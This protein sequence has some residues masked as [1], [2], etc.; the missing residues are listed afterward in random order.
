MKVVCV[1]GMP[2]CGKEEFL[3]IARSKGF[4]VVRMGD[5]VREEA[6]KAGIPLKDP[7]VGSFANEERKK[8]GFDIWAKRT[9]PRISSEFSLVDGV[10]GPAELAVYRAAFPR[11]LCVVAVHSSPAARL[12]RILKRKRKDDPA[13][14]QE[15]GARDTRELSWGLGE[16]IA[17]ADHLIVN[18]GDLASYK[19][20]ASVTIERILSGG[21]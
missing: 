16:V 13:N 8:H 21:K 9:L 4:A 5:V 3:K 15:F 14:E 1:T 2:A 10:R 19:T 6:A 7:D 11:G 18:E 20:Q 17:L 12:L